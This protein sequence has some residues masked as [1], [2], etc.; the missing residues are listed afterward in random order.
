MFLEQEFDRWLDSLS[1]DSYDDMPWDWS[2]GDSSPHDYNDDLSIIDYFYIKAVGVTYGDRQNVIKTLCVGDALRFVP[3]ENN[4]Y[5]K[6]AIMIVTESGK[7]IGYVS[8][9][10]NREIFQNIKNGVIYKLTVSNITGAEY[11]QN[12]GVNIKVYVYA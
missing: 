10:Y 11:G 3:E 9:D 8:R 4:P 5:D 12:L 2:S 7:C 1:D 6:N